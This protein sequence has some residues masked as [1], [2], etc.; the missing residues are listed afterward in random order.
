MLPTPSKTPDDQPPVSAGVTALIPLRTGGKSRLQDELDAAG[1]ASLVLAMLDDVLAALRGAGVTDIRVLCGDSEAAAA[2]QM[3]GLTVVLDPAE[4]DP[5]E[6]DPAARDVHQGLS[7][8]RPTPDGDLR[9]RRA[10]DTG[11]AAVDPGQVRLVVAADLPLLSSEEVVAM[12]ATTADVTLAPTQGGGTA[13][14]RLARGV[15]LPTQY[16]TAS[17]SAHLRVARELDLDVTQL[18]LPGARQDVDRIAD[19]RAL[20]GEGSPPSGAATSS[21]LSGRRG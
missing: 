4:R 20:E 15:S 12:L 10:V 2:A 21:F 3:R 1:R 14:L 17:A 16:G 13:I 11:L 6:R 8:D 5:A 19:L 9:L 18:D 7:A